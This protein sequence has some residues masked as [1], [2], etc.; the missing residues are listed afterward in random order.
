MT[1]LKSNQ[2]TCYRCKCKGQYEVEK[3]S[4]DIVICLVHPIHSH[5]INSVSYVMAVI[6]CVVWNSWEIKLLEGT[7][8]QDTTPTSRRDFHS[9]IQCQNLVL[10]IRINDIS[11]ETNYIQFYCVM[12]QSSHIQFKVQ[13]MI[14]E[15][16]PGNWFCMDSME[17][18]RNKGSPSQQTWWLEKE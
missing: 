15:I 5:N 18:R 17:W 6:M 2:C 3:G 1:V 11:V 7:S 9:L 14:E 13:C 10:V 4:K 8:S 16:H 12:E